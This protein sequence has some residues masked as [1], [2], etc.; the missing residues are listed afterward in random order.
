VEFAFSGDI[1]VEL[2]LHDWRFTIE[3]GFEREVVWF[4]LTVLE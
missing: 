2:G 1:V 4:G 3:R